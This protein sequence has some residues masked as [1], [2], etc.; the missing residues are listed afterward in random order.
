VRPA[1]LL[2]AAWAG[3]AQAAPPAPFEAAPAAAEFAEVF[4][5]TYAYLD[6]DDVDVEALFDRL[7]AQAA[8]A[9]DPEALAATLNRGLIALA[10]PHVR[11]APLSEADLN[12]WP[13]SSDLDG[14]A[15]PVVD[16]RAR[17]PA[18]AAGVRPGWTLQTI[19]GVGVAQAVAALIGDV[20]GAPTAGQQAYAAT[21]L[22]NGRRVGP[23]RLTF[24]TPAG[25]RAVDLANPRVPDPAPRT[26]LT[27]A[28][29][30][31]VCHVRFA[32]SL[33][34]RET[35]AAFD[36]AM[37]RCRDQPGVVLDLRD[38]PSGGNTDVAR[39]IIGHFVSEPRPYQVHTIPA[40]ARS[41]TVPRRFVEYVMPRGPAAYTGRVAAL[42]SRWTGSMGEGIVIGLHAAAGARTFASDLGDLRGALH[43]FPLELSG[44][45]V[46]L[47]AEALFHVDGTPREHYVADV[48]V[49]P[50]DRG[51]D[52]GDPA[53][54]AARAWLS[55]R[56]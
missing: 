33:G 46:E 43:T 7:E 25:A 28:V 55:S 36:A 45:T 52:G 3:A 18:D 30:D 8:G 5:G 53:L 27:I 9:S 12:V 47:G 50:A 4:R 35:I 20:A 15:W 11:V 38:T 34:Q 24:D 31:G 16:V 54:T 14:D 2:G 13:T 39:A 29:A 21:V 19:D 56:P 17:G 44:L 23:R 37:D 22:A 1:A 6:R 49:D 26:P 32:N 41:T 51:P 10:D 42:G 40:V 48:P